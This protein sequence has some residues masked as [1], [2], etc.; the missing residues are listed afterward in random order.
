[1]EKAEEILFYV[2]KTLSNLDLYSNDSYQ[3]LVNI[4]NVLQE[5]NK[6]LGMRELTLDYVYDN[7]LNKWNVTL[8]IRS[9][10]VYILKR[11]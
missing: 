9:N 6:H 8:E 7:N 4:K 5:Q 2:N 3:Y 11:W 1:M 10:F